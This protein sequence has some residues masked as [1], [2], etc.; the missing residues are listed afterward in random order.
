M[1][2]DRDPSGTEEGGSGEIGE[3]KDREMVSQQEGVCRLFLGVN[4]RSLAQQKGAPAPARI[5][6]S[7]EPGRD[8]TWMTGTTAVE[9]GFGEE[10]EGRSKDEKKKRERGDEKKEREE[11]KIKKKK[12]RERRSG[13]NS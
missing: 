8:V 10:R 1:R 6:G 3:K 5:S 4:N 7:K 11:I 12:R 9:A 2:C 13:V